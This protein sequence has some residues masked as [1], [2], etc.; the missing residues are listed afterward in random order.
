MFIS[1][2]KN[3]IILQKYL[4]YAKYRDMKISKFMMIMAAGVAAM[5]FSGCNRAKEWRQN[6]GAVW[7][8]VYTITYEADRDLSDSIQMVFRQVEN[9][10]SPFN[11]GSLV[12]RIN[13]NETVATDSLLRYVFR[14]SS[15]ICLRSGGKFDPTVSPV[16]NLW[17]FGYTGKVDADSV[18]EPSAGQIDS[19]MQFVGIRDCRILPDGKIVK[20]SAGTTFNFSAITK[21]YACDLVAD[22]LQRNGAE[23]MMVEIGGEVTVRGHNP[24][25]DAWRLQ[26]DT[27]KVEDGA[28][29]HEA[30][31]IIEVTDCGVA[32][33]GNY[34]N[35]HQSTHGRVGHTIDP[36]SGQ[37]CVTPLL[38]VTVI[39]PTCAEADAYATAAMASP[40]VAFADS[41]LRSAN[42]RAILV[43][44]N[45]DSTLSIHQLP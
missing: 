13:R 39:A 30:I 27:P 6:N 45:P 31:D 40:T 14:M 18:W 10:L 32:T 26:V 24:R 4:L 29:S 2:L 35:Y 21:G 42:L 41:I 43:T 9:S 44:A 38:S 33:S 22:M 25:G 11:E 17:K 16:V 34:R 12:S 23:N 5:M 28:P 15:V 36:V 1:A 19:A 7:N 3:F 8:T 37:P 20:K